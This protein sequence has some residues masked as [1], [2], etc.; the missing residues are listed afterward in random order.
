MVE[1]VPFDRGC[2]IALS[3]LTGFLGSRSFS[4]SLATISLVSRVISELFIAISDA[5]VLEV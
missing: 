4:G 5:R 2:V 1:V 3:G